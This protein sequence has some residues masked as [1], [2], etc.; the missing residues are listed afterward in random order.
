MKGPTLAEIKCVLGTPPRLGSRSAA[1][2]R[3]EIDFVAARA[4]FLSRAT[5]R[6]WE[7]LLAAS[8]RMHRQWLKGREI[9]PAPQP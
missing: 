4:E 3:A 6:H 9:T 1:A 5:P 7:I 8:R 2:Q